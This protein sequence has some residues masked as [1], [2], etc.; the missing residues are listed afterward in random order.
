M[1][2]I[3]TSIARFLSALFSPLLCGTYAVMLSMWL[4]FL[5]YSPVRAKLIVL[6]VTFLATC[7]LPLLS[8]FLLWK[9]G[10]IH[11]PGLNDRRDRRVPYMVTV[12][13]YAGVA[14][15]LAMVKAPLWLSM[16][17]A[18]GALALAV[19]AV[20]N[21]W[22]KMSGHAT[23]IGGLCAVVLFMLLSGVGFADLRVEFLAAVL[24]AGAVCTSRLVLERHTL[25][26]VG[27]GFATGFACTLILPLIFN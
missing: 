6:L 8:I 1:S 10:A 26:Q 2:K 23:G 12:A 9:L 13:G 7:I 20:V 18:G 5:L 15:Y 27:A 24:V 3:T 21:N 14:I 16:L 11:D 17:V 22:W 4:S 25:A 19:L